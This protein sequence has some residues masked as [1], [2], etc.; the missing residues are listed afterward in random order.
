V[1]VEFIQPTLKSAEVSLIGKA[2][3]SENPAIE[4]IQLL[5][6]IQ[7][8]DEEAFL[9][10]YRRHEKALY[11]FALHCSGSAAIAEDVVQEVFLTLL[12]R[13]EQF[14]SSRGCLANYLLGVAHKLVLRQW[15]KQKRDIPLQNSDIEDSATFILSTAAG[16]VWEKFTQE[17]AVEK[18]YQAIASLPVHYRE[19]VVLCDL[20]EKNY[21]ETAEILNCPV[22]TIR[23]RLSRAHLLLMGKM[24]PEN[25][26][27]SSGVGKNSNG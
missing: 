12:T 9:F 6:Q 21:A 26:K 19:V 7:T 10:V 3:P 20:E 8:G 1:E 5:R 2:S 16:D 18:L 13:P 11:R 14:D 23:S 4:E 27:A 24:Q 25:F 17:D 15:E 22:G